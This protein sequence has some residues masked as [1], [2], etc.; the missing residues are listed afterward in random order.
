MDRVFGVYAQVQE[1]FAK[2]FGRP[3]ADPVVG[4]RMD[5]A[6]VVLVSMGTTAATVRTVVDEAR[7]RGVK[8]GALRVRM[9]RPFPEALMK[10][11]LAGRKRVGII[12]RN[13][14]PGMG[15]VLWSETRG[16]CDGGAVVQD[17]IAGIGGGDVRP[18][19]VRNILDDLLA[20]ERGEAPRF[21]EVA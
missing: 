20:R 18:Q 16:L 9:F 10:A 3:L 5:D 2:V 17:Y 19:H 1:E 11:R 7:A 8:V 21:M 4:Y 12:D 14:S 13:L 15:G 6:D